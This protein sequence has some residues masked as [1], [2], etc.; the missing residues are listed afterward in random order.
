MSS[1]GNR[2]NPNLTRIQGH[3]DQPDPGANTNATGQPDIGR[4]GGRTHQESRD[5]NKHNTSGQEGHKP[6]RHTPSEEK[7]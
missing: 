7:H 6:Q 3:P 2:S 5:H 4:Q 1:N